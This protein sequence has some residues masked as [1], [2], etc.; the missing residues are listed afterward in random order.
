VDG[1][2]KRFVAEGSSSIHLFQIDT[3][4]NLYFNII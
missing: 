1:V 4:C 3:F 2:Y